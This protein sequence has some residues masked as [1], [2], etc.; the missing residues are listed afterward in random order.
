LAH[1][2]ETTARHPT[3]LNPNELGSKSLISRPSNR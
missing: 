2:T 1:F 3:T